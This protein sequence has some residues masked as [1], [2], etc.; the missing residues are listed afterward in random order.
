[1]L[2]LILPTRNRLTDLKCCLSSLLGKFK[3][4]NDPTEL[5][6]V[7]NSD[8]YYEDPH[9]SEILTA[10]SWEMSVRI[11]NTKPEGLAKARLEGFDSASYKIVLM[12]DDDYI[13][14]K[15]N[16]QSLLDF[17]THKDY[18]EVPFVSFSVSS[19]EDHYK[20]TH[21][22][23]GFRDKSEFFTGKHI[24]PH[25]LYKQSFIAPTFYSYPFS[26]MRREDAIWTYKKAYE[27]FPPRYR[28]QDAYVALLLVEHYK[29]WGIF[30][31]SS[32]A[33]HLDK[34][35]HTRGYIPDSQAPQEYLDLREKVSH[36]Y[37]SLKPY[38]HLTDK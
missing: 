38:L 15:F 4:E 11:L 28:G 35:C 36:R 8:T 20:W 14:G 2:S 33:Y 23:T 13:L 27:L 18:E 34:P 22:L 12:L 7:D 6:L 3:L 25:F 37:Y 17:A 1:M 16:T 19:L 5:I 10:L 9:L 26:L 30:D 29:N 24:H 31:S 21:F 32:Y